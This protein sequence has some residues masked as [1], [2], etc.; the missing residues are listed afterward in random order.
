MFRDHYPFGEVAPA[1]RAAVVPTTTQNDTRAA[2]VV[3][4]TLIPIHAAVV[5]TTTQTDTRAPVVVMNTHPNS[6]ATNIDPARTAAR[7][8]GATSSATRR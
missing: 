2:V 4:N 5:P 1:L 3:M 8:A 6:S 7:S